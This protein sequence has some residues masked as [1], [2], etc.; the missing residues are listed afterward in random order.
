[1]TFVWGANHGPCDTLSA[2]RSNYFW[3]RYLALHFDCPN[4]V[5]K[6]VASQL[7]ELLGYWQNRH[8][9][10]IE[11]LEIRHLGG[12]LD[13]CNKDFEKKLL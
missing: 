10:Q 8:A 5:Y 12:K 7:Q 6:A 11:H 4:A 1:M 9:L 2:P 3:I 13:G